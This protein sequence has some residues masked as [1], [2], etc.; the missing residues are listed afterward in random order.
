MMCNAIKDAHGM[1]FPH[2]DKLGAF[3]LSNKIHRMKLLLKSP[4]YKLTSKV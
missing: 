3:N 2:I 4:T 1:F